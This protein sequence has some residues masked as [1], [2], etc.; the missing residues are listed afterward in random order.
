MAPAV[1]AARG[2]LA[3]SYVP[4]CIAIVRLLYT[5]RYRRMLIARAATMSA[6]TRLD[7]A[8]TSISIFAQRLRGI[9]SVGL[10]AVAFVNETYK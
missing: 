8:S 7:A 5:S 3:S 1:T 10:K 6:S 2:R 9:V 4:T